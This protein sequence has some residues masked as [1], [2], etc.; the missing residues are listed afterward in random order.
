MLSGVYLAHS[1][2]DVLYDTLQNHDRSQNVSVR[3]C[4]LDHNSEHCVH[5]SKHFHKSNIS[6]DYKPIINEEML[7][8]LSNVF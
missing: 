6:R 4:F 2:N 7:K 5:R 8:Y 1:V 3:K